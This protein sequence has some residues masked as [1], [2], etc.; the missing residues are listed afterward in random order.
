MEKHSYCVIVFPDSRAAIRAQKA[1]EQA[2]MPAPVMPTPREL[3]AHCGLSLR[4]PP[5]ALEQVRAVLSAPDALPEGH[6]F[7]FYRMEYDAHTSTV[8]PME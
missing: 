4:C 2:G 5:E 3:T 8:T 6:S 7:S 1:L